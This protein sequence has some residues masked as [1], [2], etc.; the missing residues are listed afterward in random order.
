MCCSPPVPAFPSSNVII[1]CCCWLEIHWPNKSS[2]L[3]LVCRG[4]KMPPCLLAAPLSAH[5]AALMNGRGGFSPETQGWRVCVQPVVLP[6]ARDAL[7]FPPSHSREIPTPSEESTPRPRCKLSDG[8]S[9]MLGGFAGRA[10]ALSHDTGAALIPHRVP[11]PRLLP[12]AQPWRCRRPQKRSPARR[13]DRLRARR[14]C[15]LPPFTVRIFWL[16]P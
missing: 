8:I 6:P 10:S 12:W 1:F 14:R 13:E 15:V 9:A 11:C 5:P 3:L 4:E 7:S 2:L 16:S